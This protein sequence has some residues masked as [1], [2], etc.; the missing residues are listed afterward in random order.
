MFARVTDLRFNGLTG[1]KDDSRYIWTVPIR[2]KQD[3]SP[4]SPSSAVRHYP[5]TGSAGRFRFNMTLLLLSGIL[6]AILMSAN[7]MEQFRFGS[8]PEE[9]ES[10]AVSDTYVVLERPKGEVVLFMI[11]WLGIVLA[12]A[13][14][15]VDGVRTGLAKL[16]QK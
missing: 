12:L 14:I 16:R 5:P 1:V 9:D 8:A 13:S 15:A 11:G 3:G 7:G 2:I 10:L 4:L 6:L